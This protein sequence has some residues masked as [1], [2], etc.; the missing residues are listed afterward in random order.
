MPNFKS[1]VVFDIETIGFDF[2]KD[3]DEVQQEYLIKHAKS[4]EEILAAKELLGL[5]PVSGK[6]VCI[7]MH[8]IETKGGCVY[9]E[10]GNGSVIEEKKE[11]VLYKSGT[12]KEILEWF[13]EDI[14]KFKKYVTFNGRCFDVPFLRIRSAILGVKCSRELHTP[15]FKTEVH[16][17]LLE[18]LTFQGA[19]RKFNL[20]FYTKAF[21][22]KSPKD[23]VDGHAVPQMISEGRG[24]D[25]AEYCYGDVVATGEL[26]V[27]WLESWCAPETKK[28][29]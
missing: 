29:W 28:S 11:N 1:T 26:Y 20:D 24:M 19:F 17:D 23:Q 12:E 3:L 22:I 4:E 27:K 6:I 15:R 14:K 16:C 5:Y 10:T 13:W 9:F 25:V 18:E 2:E 7:A 21:G 8:N